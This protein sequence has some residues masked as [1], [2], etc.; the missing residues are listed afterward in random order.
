V[1]PPTWPP[2]HEQGAGIVAMVGGSGRFGEIG[3]Q[4]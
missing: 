3:H 1:G 4:M 2:E